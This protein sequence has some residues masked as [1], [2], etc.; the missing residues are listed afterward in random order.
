MS[1]D[2]KSD[3]NKIIYINCES[4]KKESFTIDREKIIL[5][6]RLIELTMDTDTITISTI[7]HNIFTHVI[8]YLSYRNGTPSIRYEKA[9]TETD[10][11]SDLMDEDDLKFIEHKTC[12]EL[13]NISAVACSDW[14]N[15]PCLKALTCLAVAWKIKQSNASDINGIKLLLNYD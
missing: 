12:K 1:I 4:D 2:E 6:H 3:E 11:L 15:I 13:I 9:F 14:L 7:N 5:S 10:K 8:N